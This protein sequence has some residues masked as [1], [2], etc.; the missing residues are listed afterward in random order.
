MKWRGVLVFSAILFAGISIGI[1]LRVLRLGKLNSTLEWVVPAPDFRAGRAVFPYSVIPGGV[2]DQEELWQS[3][4]HDPVVAEHYRDIRPA[5]MFPMR[6]AIDTDGYVSYRIG[7]QLFWTRQL[8]RIK[9]GELVLTDRHS[10][11]RGRCGN[12]IVPA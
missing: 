2:R 7:N 4:L 9:K 1:G 8:V 6:L 5:A 10:M 11:I 3:I 12:Q